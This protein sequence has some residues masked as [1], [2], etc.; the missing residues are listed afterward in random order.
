MAGDMVL[1]RTVF[2][3]RGSVVRMAEMLAVRSLSDMES[4]PTMV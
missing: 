1:F 3:T 2:L 4:L